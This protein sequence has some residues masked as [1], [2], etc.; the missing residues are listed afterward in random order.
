MTP[1]I[2]V[3][4]DEVPDCNELV[5]FLT[6]RGLACT[7][8]TTGSRCEIEV[9]YATDP[10]ERLHAEVSDALRTWLSE[11]TRPLVVTPV[12]DDSFVLRPPGD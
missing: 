8:V 4:L 9:A 7:P 1:A 2:H 11:H 3:E 6:R 10:E 5:G 12:G